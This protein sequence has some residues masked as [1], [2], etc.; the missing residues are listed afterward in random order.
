MKDARRKLVAVAVSAL[1][2]LA[3]CG[4]VSTAASA[5]AAPSAENRPAPARA[6]EKA[7]EMVFV[8]GSRIPQRV[9]TSRGLPATAAPVRIYSRR[10]ISQTGRPETGDALRQLDPSIP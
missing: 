5:P 7:Q 9:D 10:D 8:T 6:D 4:H 3:A 1:A 2:S